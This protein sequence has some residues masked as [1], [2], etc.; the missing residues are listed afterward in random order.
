MSFD[1]FVEIYFLNKVKRQLKDYGLNPHDWRL[2]LAGFDQCLRVE[3]IHKDDENFRFNAL[4]GRAPNGGI[5][6]NNL[7]LAS[8]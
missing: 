4:V 7:T 8:L 6:I 1:Q 2:D 5:E 3:M